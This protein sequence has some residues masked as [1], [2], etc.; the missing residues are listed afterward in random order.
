MYDYDNYRKQEEVNFEPG[1][2]FKRKVYKKHTQVKNKY[3][4]TATIKEKQ[5]V[6]Q[7]SKHHNC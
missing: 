2:N 5:F 1:G 7:H 4:L 6:T 3:M